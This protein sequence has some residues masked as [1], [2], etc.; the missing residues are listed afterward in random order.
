VLDQL[1]KKRG[2]QHAVLAVEA[3]DGSFSWVGAE[4]T[5]DGTD[6]PMTPETPY[7][8]AS[9]TKLYIAAVVLRLVE[10]GLVR[11]EE[12]FGTYLPRGVADGTHVLDSVDRT[13]EVTVRHLL[14]HAS[15]LADYLE[16]KPKTGPRFIDRLLSQADQDVPLLE[17]TRIVRDELTPH[18]PPQDLDSG[19]RVRVRYSDTNFRLLMGIIETVLDSQWHMAVRRELLEPLGLRHTWAPGGQPIEI[20]LE[21]AALWA[22]ADRLETPRM[23]ESFGDL[24]STVADQ[25]AFLRAVMCGTAFGDPTTAKRMS[26]RWH[27]FGFDPTTPRLPGW[28]IEYGL[29]MMRFALPRWYAPFMPVPPVVGHTG[30]T[31]CWL[32]Y[33]PEF[34]VYTCGG[35]DQVTAG[36][37][38]F[39]AMPRVLRAVSR[40]QLPRPASPRRF[41]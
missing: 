9:V 39:R 16:D 30:S 19:S 6:R 23:L 22:A 24:F 26:E 36:A 34:D 11:M 31:G 5:A 14:A 25:I 28:P 35:V 10:R 2:V 17:V 33:C 38:P 21:P 4:G 15:G 32:F 3:G 18:F 27:A 40:R 7:F 37:V 41:A 12:S 8:I 13:D 1:L 29:G 20:T